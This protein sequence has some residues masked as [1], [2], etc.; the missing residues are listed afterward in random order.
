VLVRCPSICLSHLAATCHSSRFAAVGPEWA[1]DIDQL[2]HGWSFA[3]ASQQRH[4]VAECGQ[5]HF[6]S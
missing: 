3:A 2:L 5:C 1:G 4:V 6:V